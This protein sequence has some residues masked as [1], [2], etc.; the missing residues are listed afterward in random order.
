MANIRTVS[1]GGSGLIARER[2]VFPIAEDP[3]PN[4]S[5][6]NNSNQ[7]GPVPLGVDFFPSVAPPPGS[8]TPNT[9]PSAVPP[10]PSA[11]WDPKFNDF[12]DP[13]LDP[14]LNNQTVPRVVSTSQPGSPQ[15][16]PRP[17]ASSGS[18]SKPFIWKK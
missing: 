5:G 9:P 17:A 1:I 12:Y 10:S 8:E 14:F 15:T 13:K 2:Q 3:D 11:V 16:P 6:S 4:Q 7:S 18:Y